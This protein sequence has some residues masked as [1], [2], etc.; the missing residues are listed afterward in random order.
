MFLKT[1]KRRNSD[2]IRTVVDFHQNGLIPPNCYVLDL[3]TIEEN[4]GII[5]H[6]AKKYNMTVFAMSKQIGRNPDALK[7]IVRGGIDSYV[8]VD[9]QCAE[10]IHRAGHKIGHIGHLVQIAESEIEPAIN[11]E[12]EFWTTFSLDKT[13]KIS[14]YC[15]KNKK[16]QKI[17]ARIYSEGDTFYRGHEGGFPAENI[18]N[19]AEKI[20][21]LDH[22]KFSG[23]TSFPAL[24]LDHETQKVA[25]MPNVDTLK[26][27]AKQLKT[28]GFKNIEINA[29][30]TTSS[31]VIPLLAEAG[32]TQIEPG[33]GLTGSTPL[34]ALEDLPEKPALLYL[35]EISHIHEG[36]PYCY[37]GGLYIDPVFPPY[38]VLC[39]AGKDPETVLNS[40]VEVEF[41]ASKTIDYYGI[42]R[43]ER[44]HNIQIG[45][46]VIMGFRAQIFVTRASIAAISG[47]SRGNPELKGLT[48]SSGRR[49]K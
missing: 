35:S 23:I 26:K 13:E 49:I 27:A 18:V 42:L 44:T 5:A 36:S 41:P 3:D 47:I 4:S 33:H 32:S 8:A 1:L 30:G 34:H 2:F 40:Y 38:P 20:N 7:A 9:I 10:S 14:Y 17:L 24:L 16:K 25:A 43:P 37:G 12:P 19:I 15:K 6:E 21:Q 46:T 45:D 48:T 39:L 28:A 29:T 22:I 11:M 31:T